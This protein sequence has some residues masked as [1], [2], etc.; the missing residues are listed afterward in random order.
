MSNDRWGFAPNPPAEGEAPE[1]AP[2]RS[3]ATSALEKLQRAL[4]AERA[5]EVVSIVLRATALVDLEAPDDRLKFAR[6]LMRRGGVL[7]AIGNSIAV[8]AILEGAKDSRTTGTFA[9]PSAADL[10]RIKKLPGSDK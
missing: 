1:D 10:E 4:G 9:R 7:E 3:P 5:R 8:Q 6:E 2:R